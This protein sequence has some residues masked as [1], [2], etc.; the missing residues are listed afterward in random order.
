MTSGTLTFP[1]GS[2]T[3]TTLT[4]AVPIIDDNIGEPTETYYV[5]LS[6]IVT[7]GTQGS[8]DLQGVGTITD[9][10]PTITVSDASIRWRVET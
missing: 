2:T 1:A 4:I 8:H 6:N 7:N 3:G 5:N 10:Y 9:V